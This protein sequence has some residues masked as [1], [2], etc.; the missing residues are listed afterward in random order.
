M[1]DLGSVHLFMCGKIE[2]CLKHEII[3]QKHLKFYNM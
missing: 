2:R 3:F 1:C